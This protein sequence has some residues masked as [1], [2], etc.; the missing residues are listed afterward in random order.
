[1]KVYLRGTRTRKDRLA[2]EAR[3]LFDLSMTLF[4]IGC[5]VWLVMRWL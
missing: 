1:M 5:L 4:A 2:G 3:N